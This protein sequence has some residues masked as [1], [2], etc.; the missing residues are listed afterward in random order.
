MAPTD[1]TADISEDIIKKVKETFNERDQLMKRNEVNKKIV[2][3]YFVFASYYASICI[4]STLF[5]MVLNDLIPLLFHIM[6]IWI[7]I[8]L[9]YVT[10][11]ITISIYHF[12]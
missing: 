5:L 3:N 9:I 11:K 10:I 12:T 4:L 2:D 6:F 1:I 7:Q 8:F